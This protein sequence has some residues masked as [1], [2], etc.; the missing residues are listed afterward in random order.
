MRRTKRTLIIKLVSGKKNTIDGQSS[1]SGPS[2]IKDKQISSKSI[3]K[4]VET[5]V[6]QHGLSINEFN[7]T[8]HCAVCTLQVPA[9]ITCVKE[10]V[11]GK[12]HKEKYLKLTFASQLNKNNIK[13]VKINDF[14]TRVEEVVSL[15]GSFLI[16]NRQFYLK[17]EDFFGLA[18]FANKLVCGFCHIDLNPDNGSAHLKSTLHRS[19]MV[20]SFVVTSLKREFVRQVIIN[21]L[22]FK[23]TCMK[24]I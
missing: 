14:I 10:H 3:N 17:L 8:V 20:N 6:K 1:S 19:I 12:K 18:M 7:N 23:V 5:F 9:T 13:T 24:V 16:I 11:F 15:R 2:Q 4:E 22:R 21:Y